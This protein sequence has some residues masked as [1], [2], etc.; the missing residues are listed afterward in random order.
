MWDSDCSEWN[1]EYIGPGIDIS[2]ELARAM[3]RE[4]LKVIMSMHHSY[5]WRYYEHAYDFDAGDP[6]YAGLYCEPHKAGDPVSEEFLKLW[7]LKIREVVDK[8]SPDVLYFDW[9]LGL[10]IPEKE[11]KEMLAYCYNKAAERDQDFVFVYKYEDLPTGAGLLD[12]ESR[13]PGEKTDFFWMTD[14]SITAWFPCKTAPY[15]EDHKIIHMLADI[16]SKNG[17]LLLNVPPDHDGRL[18]ERARR[19][20]KETG[21]WLEINGEAIY[22]TRPWKTFGEGPTMPDLLSKEVRYRDVDYTSSDIRFTR[23]K[24]GNTVYAIVLGWPNTDKV[25]IE[26]L[27]EVSNNIN[28]ISLL[29][30]TG[31]IK[32]KKT[33]KAVVIE[34]P[35]TAPRNHAIALKINL[36]N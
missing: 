15:I 16:A 31:E 3:R 33:K 28:Q 34:L 29:G 20:L 5:S 22:N 35:D 32:W 26:S 27:K 24:D 13:Y 18:N 2:G 19:I 36:E 8:Y 25:S 1:S 6:R 21:N 4:G 9:G 17:C 23:S 12:H 7:F 14:L 11:R 30:Y 10:L